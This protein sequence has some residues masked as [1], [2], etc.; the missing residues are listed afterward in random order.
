M[1]HDTTKLIVFVCTGNICRSPIAEYVMRHRLGDRTQWGVA[2]AGVFA[3]EGAP[4]SQGAV[5]ALADSNIDAS[6]HRSQML[7]DELVESATLL[8]VMTDNHKRQVLSYFP[9]AES[10]VYCL[11]EFGVGTSAEDVADPIGQSLSVYRDTYQQIDG[12]LSDLL[13]YMNSRWGL[14]EPP[15]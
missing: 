6:Q 15:S 11:T 14:S 5:Q 8:A 2:S 9:N 3:T 12:A 13:L 4:A 7:T 1:S 10:K